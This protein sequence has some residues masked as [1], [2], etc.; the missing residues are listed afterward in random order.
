MLKRI[1]K[2][3][4]STF[5][6]NYHLSGKCYVGTRLKSPIASKTYNLPTQCT[7]LEE[8]LKNPIK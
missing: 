7:E 1:S 2:V 8:V 5:M 3:P 6:I 4:K